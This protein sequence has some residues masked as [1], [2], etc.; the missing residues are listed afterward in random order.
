MRSLVAEARY[1]I[2][3]RDQTANSPQEDDARTIGAVLSEQNDEWTVAR[4]YM[5]PNL[6]RQARL[7]VVEAEMLEEEVDDTQQLTA[8]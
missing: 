6:L 7:R 2:A 8:G 5:N 3:G 4:R 1:D